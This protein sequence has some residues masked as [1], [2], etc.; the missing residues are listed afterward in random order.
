MGKIILAGILRKENILYLVTICIAI[1][2]VVLNIF[3]S[4]RFGMQIINQTII[5][6]LTLIAMAN[7]VEHDTLT[8]FITACNMSFK[9]LKSHTFIKDNDKPEL[10]ELAKDAS[11]FFVAGAQSFNV[12]KRHMNF[13][14]QWIRDGKKLKILALNPSNEGLKN[15]E[16]PLSHYSY[17]NYVIEMKSTL[18]IIKSIGQEGNPNLQIRVTNN[19]L[20]QGL[21]IVDGHKGGKIMIVAFYLPNCD[22]FS[23]PHVVLDKETDTEWF[24][25]FYSKY[26]KYLWDKADVF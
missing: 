11:E 1:V 8:K 24:N 26:Y 15:L 5:V 16:I 25:L 3:F 17:E 9:K 14:E 6:L 18:K 23:R 19:C 12:V 2:V 21:V 13:W 10:E 22:P 4:E 20:C 7:L